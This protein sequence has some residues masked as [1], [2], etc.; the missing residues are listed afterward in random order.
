MEGLSDSS[1]PPAACDVTGLAVFHIYRQ[2]SRPMVI[3]APVGR[4]TDPS[5]HALHELL[6]AQ[7]RTLLAHV[8]TRVPWDPLHQGT[9]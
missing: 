4:L 1:H 6:L 5:P 8:G 9:N 2:M 7:P 3:H